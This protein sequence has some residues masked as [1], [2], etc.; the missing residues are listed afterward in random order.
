MNM[1]VLDLLNMHI[2]IQ[3]DA[4][5]TSYKSWYKNTLLTH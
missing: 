3:K 4:Y 2:M 5:C 1:N